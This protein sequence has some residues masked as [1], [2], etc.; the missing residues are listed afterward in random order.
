M[1]SICVLDDQGLIRRLIAETA[2]EQGHQAASAG[3]I[4]EGLTLCRE[5]DFDVI[6]LDIMLPDGNGL[7]LI[8][9][10]RGL[11]SRPEIVIITGHGDPEGAELAIRH[12]AWDYLTKPLSV[13]KLILTLNRVVAFRGRRREPAPQ[14]GP[15]RPAGI[16]GQSPAL[17]ACL[18]A[19]SQAAGSDVNV[20]L[21]GETG[22]GKDVFARAIHEAGARAG[23]PLVTL[24]CASITET[25]LEARMFGHQKGAF[26]GAD[27]SRPGVVLAAHRGTLFLDEIGELP[28]S[29]Q[30]AFLRVLETRRFRPIGARDEVASDF[31][32][33]A[34]TNRNLA[35]MAELDLFRPD[36][37]YRLKG[38][39]ITLPPLRQR[40]E[41]IPLLCAHVLEGIRT[42]SGLPGKAL[43]EE[44]LEF[45][46]AHDWPGNV[47]ELAQAL[48]RAFAAARDEGEIF[49]WHLPLDLRTAVARNRVSRG[50]QA[51]PG[52]APRPPEASLPTYREYRDSTERSYLESL[53]R[54]TPNK[55]EAARLSGLSR[56]HLYQLLK[57]HGLDR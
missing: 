55:A 17:A 18:E 12:G 25:L 21:L 37:L 14:A 29:M 4:A 26:T 49:S 32:L 7:D 19:A 2:A 48:E 51:A 33:I 11:P 22:T 23:G 36:L 30:R 27:Q 43:S 15:F 40:K 50:S 42:R 44:A 20:L 13:E 16:V 24:D 52:P 41:D 1:A 3:T 57:K 39:V 53:L 54:Q 34:A 6:F 28:P 45:L 47:R 5:Q 35:E 9:A 31:R 10:L 46:A 56:G 38:I 8:P